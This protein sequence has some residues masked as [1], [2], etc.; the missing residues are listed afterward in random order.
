MTVT[1]QIR[2]CAICAFESNSNAKLRKH[3]K[4]EH[5]LDWELYAIQ[6]QHDGKRPVCK[7][8][9]GAAV[10]FHDVTCAFNSYVLGHNEVSMSE[11]TKRLVGVKNS[12]NMKRYYAEHIEEGKL[13]AQRMR[14]FLTDEVLRRRSE[15]VRKATTSVEF[16]QKMS[17]NWKAFWAN[18]PEIRIRRD[19]S[20]KKTYNTRALCG[21]YEKT[22]QHLSEVM[23]KKLINN[24]RIWQ[25]GEYVPHKSVK[26]LCRYKSS[27]ELKAMIELDE[28]ETVIAW[29]YESL[30]IQYTD[31]DNAKHF[32]IPDFTV[33][34]NVGKTF[35]VEVK[36]AKLRDKNIPKFEAAALYC[37]QNNM[38]FAVWEPNDGPICELFRTSDE[39]HLD[40]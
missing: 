9:C 30:R 18:N 10:K 13:R 22:R 23:S 27:Y 3:V 35:I 4:S 6:T 1:W 11:E 40:I 26:N 31:V 24:E 14:D 20:C 2:K 15:A 7:C 39:I 8:G 19:A 33:H 36:P 12:K 16:R 34:T 21:A 28:A 25:C 38:S 37:K 32:Y 17:E 29:E 5:D